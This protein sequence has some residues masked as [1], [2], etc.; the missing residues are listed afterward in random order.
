[1]EYKKQERLGPV[2]LECGDRIMYGRTDK[3]YCSDDCRM[4]HYNSLAKQGRACRRKTLAALF[5]NHAI[6]DD[7]FRK[8]VQSVDMIDIVAM[9][10]VPGIV[11][12][13]MRSGKHD[14]FRCFDIRYIM[15]PTRIYA[16]SKTKEL[17]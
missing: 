8:G 12:S 16:I 4:K 10:F 2:C 1:M 3:K 15:T 17:F 9:G 7:L 11:T 6:L 13:Y 5:R 14:E